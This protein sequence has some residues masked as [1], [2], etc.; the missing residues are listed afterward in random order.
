MANE[1]LREA[2]NRAVEKAQDARVMRE[3]YEREVA[4]LTNKLHEAMRSLV[5]AE[6]A[7]E[8]AEHEAEYAHEVMQDS[9]I[10]AHEEW[11]ATQYDY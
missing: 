9:E 2:V 4:E 8:A 7:E 3:T 6:A 11:L 1:T 10:A 5:A